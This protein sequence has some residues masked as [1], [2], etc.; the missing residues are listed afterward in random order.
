LPRK[1]KEILTL[2][3]F[4]IIV[5]L[6]IGFS[7][8]HLILETTNRLNKN[9]WIYITEFKAPTDKY[10]R[11]NIQNQMIVDDKLFLLFFQKLIYQQEENPSFVIHNIKTRVFIPYPSYL[12]VFFRK[13]DSNYYVFRLARAEKIESGFFKYVKGRMI[14]FKPI[15]EGSFDKD[16][17]SNFFI[18]TLARHKGENYSYPQIVSRDFKRDLNG[19]Y[20]DVEVKINQ[21]N[22]VAFVN[23][24]KIAEYKDDEYKTGHCGLSTGDHPAIYIDKIEIEG[25]KGNAPFKFIED[26]KNP[27][28]NFPDISR[29]FT[30]TLISFLLIWFT[31]SYFISFILKIDL[32]KILT[33]DLFT[34]LPYVIAFFNPLSRLFLLKVNYQFISW[35]R[36]IIYPSVI[37]VF[38]KLLFIIIHKKF[39]IFYETKP[40]K[41][42]LKN[43][44]VELW[45]NKEIRWIV[46]SFPL[47]F[48]IL[49]IIGFP[50]K[51][52]PPFDTQDETLVT[53]EQIF[54]IGD[55]LFSKQNNIRDFQINLN[56]FIEKD[57]KFEIFFR[58]FTN[59]IENNVPYWYA[60]RL[61]TTSQ[62]P[63]IGFIKS[64]GYKKLPHKTNIPLN[65]WSKIVIVAKG[66]KMSVTL[67][68]KR[69]DEYY[70][71][72]YQ[73]G[74]IGFIPMTDNLKIKNFTITEL[75]SE[76]PNNKYIR[77][78]QHIIRILNEMGLNL[79]FLCLGILI[80]AFLSIYSILISSILKTNVKKAFYYDFVT[81]LPPTFIILLFKS[82]QYYMNLIYLGILL[83]FILK[84]LYI[85]VN[86]RQPWS[87]NL[88]TLIFCILFFIT[89]EKAIKNSRYDM[90][91]RGS[92][93]GGYVRDEFIFYI[94]R[95]EEMWNSYTRSFIYCDEKFSRVKSKDTIRI[96]CQGG[97]ATLGVGVGKNEER[98][99]QILGQL[100]NEGNNEKKYEVIN[101]GKEA[102]TTLDGIIQLKRDLLLL[103]PDIVTLMFAG[104]DGV[105]P[106]WLPY[107]QLNVWKQIRRSAEHY[108]PFHHYLFN[109][110]L[111]TGIIKEIKNILEI[112]LRVKPQSQV[113][114]ED[115]EQNLREYI[116]LSKENNFKLIFIYEMLYES[117]YLKSSF[118]KPYYE[119]MKKVAQENNIPL[120]D[121]IPEF[122]K[123]KYDEI[124][125]DCIHPTAL[126]NEIIAKAIKEVINKDLKN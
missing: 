62:I 17:P 71:K 13:A 72:D 76:N 14:E 102:N 55:T 75:P 53:N 32:R 120:V 115:F 40:I 80:P 44:I 111:F 114:I 77:T 70:D 22:F 60:F 116:R 105:S 58:K 41:Y 1:T 78:M 33:F 84:Y 42:S 21:G 26:F 126:G 19:K 110:R 104:N 39:L 109:C 12:D 87:F 47:L 117:L 3:I 59:P 101:A 108:N 4:A 99:P 16:I 119:T 43:S 66:N 106:W 100:L 103:K 30:I 97:S 118:F 15:Y 67:D 25:I 93:Q 125:V 9:T 51:N 6:L 5:S 95:A 85:I 79:M 91:W 69:G 50:L 48:L 24:K 2:L 83:S 38:L 124:L 52:T 29:F 94:F 89:G 68:N 82:N 31:Y 46:F 86:I 10:I 113:P 18:G 27:R 96:I 112:F 56:V 23:G 36:L 65:Q 98:Y 45:S 57:K 88:L 122:Q 20:Y 63:K 37:T 64:E 34:Y 123:H 49:G 90:F 74:K 61:D 28:Y 107:T 54:N 73:S 121:T 35:Y 92:W 11:T 7:V 8:V 81:L